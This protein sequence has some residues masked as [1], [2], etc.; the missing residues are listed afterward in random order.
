MNKKEKFQT[1]DATVLAQWLK[2]HI[3]TIPLNAP[4]QASASLFVLVDVARMESAKAVED[5]LKPMCAEGHN[6]INLYADFGGHE[7][8]KVGPRLCRL[9]VTDNHLQQ[10]SQYALE[11]S[12]ISFLL[13]RCT[14]DALAQH[15]MDVREVSLP[16]GTRALFRFQDVNVT[17]ALWPLLRRDQVNRLLGPLHQWIVL[18]ICGTAQVIL[19]P[20][21][22]AAKDTLTLMTQQLEFLDGTLLVHTVTEQVNQTDETLLHGLTPCATYQLLAQRIAQARTLGLRG[23]SDISLY[24]VLSLQFP[25]GF[26]TQEPFAR[27]LDQARAG[28][29]GFGTALDGAPPSQWQAWDD[30]LNLK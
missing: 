10:V 16:D 20:K 24:C 8:S 5:R 28:L 22:Y 12:A 29:T 17:A 4:E 15:L 7:V 11:T 3:E 13:G 14:T 9:A 18:D 27:A 1:R 6:P 21:P 19:Q 23:N 25:P 30:K 2:T 26:E